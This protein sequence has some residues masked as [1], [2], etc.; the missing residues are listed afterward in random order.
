MVN[1][2]S[3]SKWDSERIGVYCSTLLLIL[4]LVFGIVALSGF[5]GDP[6]SVVAGTIILAFAPLVL[7][8]A[9]F[10][11][12]VVLYWNSCRLRYHLSWVSVLAACLGLAVVL[13]LN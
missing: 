11:C 6:D 12:W 3:K 2:N 8:P 10:V 5:V 4:P 9:S 7:V 1:R 13:G